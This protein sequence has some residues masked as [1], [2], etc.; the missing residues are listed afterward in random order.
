M[1]KDHIYYPLASD[2]RPKC[3]ICGAKK[4][5][6]PGWKDDE[7]GWTAIGGAPLK[8]CIRNVASLRDLIDKAG[9][10]GPPWGIDMLDEALAKARAEGLKDG[11]VAERERIRA[12][13]TLLGAVPFEQGG[14]MNG[15]RGSLEDVLY[16]LDHE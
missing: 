3:R 4:Q 2:K 1:S 5:D 15:W 7:D 16:W 11:K 12:R 13:I 10:G 9:W 14:Y 6:C 8:E